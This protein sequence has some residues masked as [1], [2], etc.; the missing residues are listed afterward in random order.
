M[1]TKVN[2]KALKYL[3]LGGETIVTVAAAL[4]I[5]R[6]GWVAYLFAIGTLAFAIGRLAQSNE[7]LLAQVHVSKRLNV[8]RLLR[9]KSFAVV[10]LMLAAALM[11]VSNTIYLG[12]DIYIF[13]SSWQVPFL[14]FVVIEVYT[15]FRLPALIEKK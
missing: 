5:T 6:M 8:R 11:Q 4:W 14:C 10:F 3:E 7:E 13:P 12:Q 1:R 2:G 15:A 9:Q